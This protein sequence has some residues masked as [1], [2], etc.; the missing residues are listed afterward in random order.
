M[1]KAKAGDRVRVQ[2]FPAGRPGRHPDGK[3]LDFTVGSGEVI[4][5]ISL[6]VVGMSEGEQRHLILQPQDAYGVVR[7]HLIKELPRRNFPQHLDLRPG[8]RLAAVDAAGRRRPV[9]VVRVNQ[10]SVVV[11]ANH[12]LAG[13][14]LEVDIR[15]L[16]L[17]P[18]YAHR[19]KPQF[20]VGGEG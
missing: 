19:D 5:G 7:P 13:E 14:V 18:S 4:P 2:Y 1:H 11:D 15:L 12:R 6:G 16:S 9:T 17:M 8:K 10:D 3:V 20:D